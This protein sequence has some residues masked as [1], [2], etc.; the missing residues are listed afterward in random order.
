MH[1]DALDA[2]T[3]AASA[4]PARIGRIGPGMTSGG[5]RSSGG[6]DGTQCDCPVRRPRNLL[7][8]SFAPVTPPPPLPPPMSEK[9]AGF[10]QDYGSCR[11]NRFRVD[12]CVAFR[13]VPPCPREEE[14]GCN[15]ISHTGFSFLF[16]FRS[17][18]DFG[19]CFSEFFFRFVTT[20]PS[21]CSGA[22]ERKCCGVFALA[23]VCSS[24]VFLCFFLFM[25][26]I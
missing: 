14:D 12:L 1:A 10:S 11:R 24:L 9:V 22:K 19:F 13:E 5:R 6:R 3:G 15:N 2:S 20:V 17:S 4:I 7:R 26:F 8:T 21:L 16:F 25:C 23:L 18:F